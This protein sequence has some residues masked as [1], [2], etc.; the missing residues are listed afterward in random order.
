DNKC[1]VLGRTGSGK[2]ALLKRVQK[3]AENVI[4]IE[5]ESLS[6][7]YVCNSNVIAFFEEAGVSLDIFYTLLWR[8]IFTVELLKRKF[9]IL[10]EEKKAEFL[11]FIRNVFTRD[12]NK[13]RALAY[14][15]K[16]GSEFWKETEYRT[17]EFTTKLETELKASAQI[18]ADVIRAG[19]EGAHRL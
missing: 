10:N 18:S 1:V 5:P 7:N 14:L 17:K 9:E 4:E 2:T 3:L 11:S 15:E 16:W 13:E 6:L 12:K 19:A 8:H